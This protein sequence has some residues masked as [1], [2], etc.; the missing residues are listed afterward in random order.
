M[1]RLQGPQ[2]LKFIVDQIA[3]VLSLFPDFKPKPSEIKNSIRVS[4]K[5][6]P[7]EFMVHDRDS[8]RL[9][10]SDQIFSL[11]EKNIKKNV[12]LGVGYLILEAWQAFPVS[13]DEKD[14][15]VTR[16]KNIHPDIERFTGLMQK[17]KS[18]FQNYLQIGW[19]EKFPLD[20]DPSFTESLNDIFPWSFCI[21]MEKIMDR[22][23][24]VHIFERDLL[25]KDEQLFEME[26]LPVFTRDL[27]DML[28]QAQMSVG[29]GWKTV[30]STFAS[31]DLDGLLEL[32]KE[33]YPDLERSRSAIDDLLISL[34]G[35]LYF[36]CKEEKD[37]GRQGNF[38]EMPDIFIDDEHNFSK[39]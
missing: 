19:N 37:D 38:K 17:I 27:F 15:F 22:N 16:F 32:L 1:E 30:L 33:I 31:G 3:P 24:D 12:Y 2:D 11:D 10:F 14:Y 39:S 8:D 25:N 21:V 18:G 29:G 4:N 34:E 5:L 9:I 20:D 13:E 6:M 28:Y 35:D 26:Q 36:M 7:Q 23:G